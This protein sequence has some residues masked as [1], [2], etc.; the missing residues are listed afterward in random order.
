MLPN[1]FFVKPLLWDKIVVVHLIRCWVILGVNTWVLRGFLFSFPTQSSSLIWLTIRFNAGVNDEHRFDFPWTCSS[2]ICFLFRHWR[3]FFAH[4]TEAEY[5]RDGIG[6]KIV[7]IFL[8]YSTTSFTHFVAISTPRAA[9]FLSRFELLALANPQ[10]FEQWDCSMS[11]CFCCLSIVAL[12]HQ[13]SCHLLSN[14]LTSSSS[15]RASVSCCWFG[16]DSLWSKK[17]STN[18]QNVMEWCSVAATPLASCHYLV[19]SRHE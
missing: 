3:F 8:F 5:D 13:S 11:W 9:F 10:L 4:T 16:C 17:A 7:D 19:K 1:G 14:M 12:W 18:L 15:S 6:L 2:K